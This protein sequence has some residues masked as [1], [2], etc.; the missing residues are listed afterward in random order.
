M[1]LIVKVLV[2]I[3]KSVKDNFTIG[4]GWTIGNINSICHKNFCCDINVVV[5]SEGFFFYPFFFF[6]FVLFFMG[7]MV[8][9]KKKEKPEVRKQKSLSS[10]LSVEYS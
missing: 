8:S 5:W 1:P 6:C 2:E 4:W 3:R 7:I 9:E 10:C